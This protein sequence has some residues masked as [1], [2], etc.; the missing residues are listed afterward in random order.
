LVGHL[1]YSLSAEVEFVAVLEREQVTAER[2]ELPRS[3]EDHKLLTR[4][5]PKPASAD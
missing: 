4:E 3:S 1:V 5:E 2:I